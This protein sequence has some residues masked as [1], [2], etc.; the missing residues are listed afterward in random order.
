MFSP[1]NRAR[2]ATS[3]SLHH[4]VDVTDLLQPKKHHRRKSDTDFV[5]KEQKKPDTDSSE[6]EKASNSIVLD[7]HRGSLEELTEAVATSPGDTEKCDDEYKA[8]SNRTDNSEKIKKQIKR[9]ISLPSVIAPSITKTPPS[10]RRKRPVHNHSMD[11]DDCHQC[12]I[13]NTGGSLLSPVKAIP[14]F[15]T[16]SP[17]ADIISGLTNEE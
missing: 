2:S 9:H 16:S 14:S 13:E 1:D 7:D 11:N 4:N 6:N 10:S 17:L 15:T 3:R 5:S 8:D 12:H